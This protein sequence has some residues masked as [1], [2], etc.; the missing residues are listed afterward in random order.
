MAWLQRASPDGACDRSQFLRCHPSVV[1]HPRPVG[2]G[3]HERQA[4]DEFGPFARDAG[5]EDA[6]LA[7]MALDHLVHQIQADPEAPWLGISPWSTCA[8]RL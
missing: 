1:G 3:I 5:T 7:T 4:H 2:L 6:D 8:D